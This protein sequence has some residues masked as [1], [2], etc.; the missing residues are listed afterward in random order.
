MYV[1][2]VLPAI[3][4]QNTSKMPWQCTYIRS[5]EYAFPQGD[6]DDEIYEEVEDYGEGIKMV[7]GK[8]LSG[9]AEEVEV[10]LGELIGDASI[11][12][13]DVVMDALHLLIGEIGDVPIKRDPTG[14]NMLP[15]NREGC[16]YYRDDATKHFRLVF[17][18]DV[19][20][21][22]GY[23]LEVRPVVELL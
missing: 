10:D 6:I 12:T 20:K 21:A 7:F 3:S 23:V 2:I 18:M 11:T 1:V 13:P 14:L 4:N 9:L 22:H 19:D 5:F 16:V 15:F 8:F 17:N